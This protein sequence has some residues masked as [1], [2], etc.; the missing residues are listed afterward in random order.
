M[1]SGP[2]NG[3]RVNLRGC[4]FW[5]TAYTT[6]GKVC[7]KGRH[8]VCLACG[9]GQTQ[10][11]NRYFRF[12]RLLCCEPTLSSLC[13]PTSPAL[14]PFAY[15]LNLY[16]APFFISVLPS[17]RGFVSLPSTSPCG[18]LCRC[19]AHF[20]NLALRPGSRKGTALAPPSLRVALTSIP[21]LF[22]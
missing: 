1:L 16:L 5:C 22:P 12:S 17:C 20:F 7:G 18:F 21:S 19:S 13:Y 2:R 9:P 15:Y 11:L 3:G 6:Q 10:P 14:F 8:S 4:I